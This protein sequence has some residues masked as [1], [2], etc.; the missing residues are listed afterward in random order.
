MLVLGASG[1]ALGTRFL[2]TPESTY[3]LNQKY[4][5]LAAVDTV[6]T[7]AFDEV[8]STTGWPQGVDGRALLNKTVEDKAN[9]IGLEERKKLFLEAVKNDDTSRG[10]TWAGTSI[11]LM[12]EINGAGVCVSQYD[13]LAAADRGPP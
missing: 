13:V 12:N 4:A 9:G 6:R 2:L 5:L 8:R 3:S 11:G 7:L 1:A 10:V